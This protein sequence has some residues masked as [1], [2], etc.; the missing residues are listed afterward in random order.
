MR[1]AIT[2]KTQRP[3]GK[4]TRIGWSGC[5]AMLAGVD[6]LTPFLEVYRLRRRRSARSLPTKS[7]EPDFYLMRGAV[8]DERER[9]TSGRD[10]AAVD[11]HA[12]HP[13]GDAVRILDAHL[14]ARAVIAERDREA[15]PAARDAGID[16]Q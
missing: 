4:A 6:M 1:S 14:V 3:I 5:L 10:L 11:L 15:R 12:R 8:V 13:T 7:A 16:E 2:E 9:D